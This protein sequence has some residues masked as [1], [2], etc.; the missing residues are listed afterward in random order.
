MEYL[1]KQM[2]ALDL[3]EE[4]EEVWV[5][6]TNLELLILGLLP[7]TKQEAKSFDPFSKAGGSP[8]LPGCKSWLKFAPEASLPLAPEIAPIGL[9]L[10]LAR[11]NWLL[12]V[13]EEKGS[14]LPPDMLDDLQQTVVWWDASDENT[15]PLLK[16]ILHYFGHN[17]MG[18]APDW[19]T[20][21]REVPAFCNTTPFLGDP[22]LRWKGRV[23][24]PT[25]LLQWWWLQEQDFGGYLSAIASKEGDEPN[26][27]LLY[28]TLWVEWDED[29]VKFPDKLRESRNYYTVRLG[30]ACPAWVDQ[31][32]VLWGNQ[33]A[34]WSMSGASLG[35]VGKAVNRDATEL[36]APARVYGDPSPL[37]K[38]QDLNTVGHLALHLT[39][40]YPLGR[41][42]DPMIPMVL[43]DTDAFAAV[44]GAEL[45]YQHHLPVLYQHQLE[46]VR[47]GEIAAAC[48][49]STITL[50]V[51]LRSGKLRRV[52]LSLGQFLT[53]KATKLFNR[54]SLLGRC[55]AIVEAI[56]KE[57]DEANS[58]QDLFE[59]LRRQAAE[60]LQ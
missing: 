34:W 6:L 49:K 59:A 58:D 54:D 20:T 40:V 10:L 35:T 37:N 52:Q 47:V 3:A 60:R 32:H 27:L 21:G 5:T 24:T 50:V 57:A 31:P 13:R 53:D 8:I 28:N 26:K 4:L 46:S 29:G 33:L 56:R 38:S 16:R 55:P 22:E 23:W 43:T 18:L 2:A 51:K 7:I 1:K 12:M 19:K 17:M 45:A 39:K 48:G 11:L 9:D 44:I 30:K 41:G 14:I 25:D 42:T 36:V 15:P